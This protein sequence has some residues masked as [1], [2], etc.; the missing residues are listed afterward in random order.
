M[1]KVKT[2]GEVKAGDVLYCVDYRDYSVVEI[3]A[4][5]VTK[6][7]ND[8]KFVCITVTDEVPNTT[9]K[10]YKIEALSYKSG[11]YGVFTTRRE[12][13][14]YVISEAEKRIKVAEH[15]IA[16][17]L[18]KDIA[19]SR[20]VIDDNKPFLLDDMEEKTGTQRD[21]SYGELADLYKEFNEKVEEQ[22]IEFPDD[23]IRQQCELDFIHQYM[24]GEN[25]PVINTNW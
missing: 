10:P 12:A 8:D 7:G 19:D 21:V 24:D 25:C 3:H 9:E 2:W 13:A 17:K 16:D 23:E 18:L 15:E 22:G 6:F 20:K 1:N 14:E 11:N 5:E 4:A